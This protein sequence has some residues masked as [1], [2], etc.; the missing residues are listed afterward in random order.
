[1]KRIKTIKAIEEEVLI[2]IRGLKRF[3]TNFQLDIDKQLKKGNINI[4]K[5][6]K[7]SL[8]KKDSTVISEYFVSNPEPA[9]K[10]GDVFI[11]ETSLD[12][13]VYEYSSYIHGESKWEAITGNVD[14]DKVI[15]RKDFIGAGNWDGFGT[16]KKTTNGTVKIPANG[17]SVQSFIESLV[18]E[19]LQPKITAQPSVTGFT[20]TGAKAVEAGTKLNQVTFGTATLNKGSYTYGPEDTGV[21]ATTYKIDRICVP[22]TY[23]KSN[24]S[25]SGS[26]TDNNEGNGFIIGDVEGTNV[27]QSLKYKSSI[28]HTDG[29]VAEDNLGNPSQPEVKI[30]AGTKS[31]DTSAYTPFRSYFYG[32]TAE[33]PEI[34]SAYIRSLTNSN[35][36]YSSRTL[37]IIVPAGTQR[38]AIA[39][40]STARGVTRVINETALNA[41]VTATFVK[42]TVRVEGANA[43]APKDYNVWVF[44][45]AVAYGQQAI[46]KVTL[47]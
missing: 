43:Y 40:I 28:T 47:G 6:T 16:I 39:C 44:E 14:A 41:D 1:M 32:A 13:T 33:K 8:E 5:S 29:V 10:K 20:L 42:S 2:N 22:D 7:D 37:T 34:D 36:P 4:F 18:S 3:K 19:K 35:A 30:L 11:I 15:L 26:G 27:V 21:Q 45:P 25:A 31:K 23:S 12:G 38:V 46:L 24:V 9:P 17:K